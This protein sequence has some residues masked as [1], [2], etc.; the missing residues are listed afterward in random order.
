MKII[1]SIAFRLI[2]ATLIAVSVLITGMS[3][4]SYYN[5]KTLLEERQ[6]QQLQHAVSRLELNLPTAVW[7]FEQERIV[8]IL[9]SEQASEHIAFI[10][11]INDKDEVSATAGDNKTPQKMSVPLVFVEDDESSSIGQLAIYIDDNSI[12]SVLGDLLMTSVIEALSLGLLIILI[13]YTLYKMLIAKPLLKLTLAL[14]NMD[15]GQSDLTHRLHVGN[16]DEF[17]RVSQG[18]NRF[19]EMIQAIVRAFQQSVAK[20][21]IQAMQANEDARESIQLIEAQQQETDQMATAITQ[22]SSSAGEVASRV[23][24]TAESA[25][26]ARKDTQAVALI[27]QETVTSI[28]QLALQLKSSEHAINSLDENVQG[29]VSVMDV[30]N[31]VAEQTNLLALN[32]A[33]EAARAGEHGRGFAVVADEVRGLAQR[34]QAS[35]L[36]IKE[37]IDGLRTSTNTAVQSTLAS[38][39]LSATA[40]DNAKRSEASITD[41]LDATSSISSMS[42]QIATAVN[43]QSHVAEELSKSVNQIVSLGY[44]NTESL[45][46]VS[47]TIQALLSLSKDLDELAQRFI[48]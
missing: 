36:E 41:I 42:E 6:Q 12:H 30:I 10:E 27:L 7:N 34:T 2:V 43:E 22:M 11:F 48:T 5:Q 47:D 18:F 19:V 39:E 26:Q 4:V 45:N 3:T 21:S 38:F 37:K 8:N 13:T 9:K 16:K 29:I 44:D 1:N 32:A 35:T 46:K 15:R 31:G 28:E 40:V 20:T 33:I 23:N 25:E 24:Q 14:E 17:E